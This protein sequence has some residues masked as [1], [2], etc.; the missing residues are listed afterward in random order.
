MID[1]NQHI[2]TKY[3]INENKNKNIKTIQVYDDEDRF[4]IIKWD[5]E[6][7]NMP[8]LY[9]VINDDAHRDVIYHTMGLPELQEWLGSDILDILKKLDDPS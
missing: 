4:I 2:K 7:P 5:H 3:Q 1:S 9:H 8:A 6:H